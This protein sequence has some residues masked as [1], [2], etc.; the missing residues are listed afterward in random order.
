MCSSLRL[1]SKAEVMPMVAMNRMEESFMVE[2]K[3]YFSVDCG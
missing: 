1:L 3:F 2:S